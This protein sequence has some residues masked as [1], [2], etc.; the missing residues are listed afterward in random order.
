MSADP[1]VGGGVLG[2]VDA[3]QD[4]CS[5]DAGVEESPVVIEELWEDSSLWELLD[6]GPCEGG[7]RA[8]GSCAEDDA[9]DVA[10]CVGDGVAEA[11]VVGREELRAEAVDRQEQQDGPVNYCAQARV[12]LLLLLL[13]LLSRRR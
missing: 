4:V 1:G 6:N 12:H 10:V 9:A 7:G 5:G 2:V 3:G 8:C 11:K 13:L